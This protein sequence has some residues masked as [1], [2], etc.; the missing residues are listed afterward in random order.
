[1]LEG[2]TALV[3]GASSGIGWAVATA[4]ARD[5]AQLAVGARRLE[6]L[7]DLEKE[8]AGAGGRALA[9]ELDVTDEAAC[10]VAVQRAVD[11]FGTLD[12]LVNNAGVMLFGQVEGADT[13][14]WRLIRPTDQ[15]W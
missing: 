13:E 8:I 4:L 2:R 15:A 6:R 7:T 12:I 9:L 1:M 10:R 3:T 5:G 11:E 14:D